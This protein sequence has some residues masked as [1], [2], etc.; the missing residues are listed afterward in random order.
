MP[1]KKPCSA[2]LTGRRGGQAILE[3]CTD[4]VHVYNLAAAIKHDLFQRMALGYLQS[5]LYLQDVVGAARA[6]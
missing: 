3:D 5:S 4:V 6:R 2:L 1:A